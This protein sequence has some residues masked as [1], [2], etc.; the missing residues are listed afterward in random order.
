MPRIPPVRVPDQLLVSLFDEFEVWNKIKDGRLS[1]EPVAEKDAPSWRWPGAT[2][3]IL[4]HRL[5][6]GKHVITTH[7]A[8]SNS[9]EILHW[10]GKD[11][12]MQEVRLYRV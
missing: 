8:V 4:K 7:C 11:L 10:D 5:S 12:M 9:G 3:R 6:N 1:T 2:S